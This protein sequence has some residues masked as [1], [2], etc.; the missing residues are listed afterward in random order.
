MFR[1][2]VEG[3]GPEAADTPDPLWT[4]EVVVARVVDTFGGERERPKIAL[5][6]A[7]AVSKADWERPVPL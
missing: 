6:A 4:P 2:V 3:P 1:P 7:A 5:C